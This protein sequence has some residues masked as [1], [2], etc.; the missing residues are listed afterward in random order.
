VRDPDEELGMALNS[1]RMI[2]FGLEAVW[3]AVDTLADGMTIDPASA[4]R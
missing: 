2:R 3:N 1:T 4:P